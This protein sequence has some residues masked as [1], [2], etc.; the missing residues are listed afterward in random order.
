MAPENW[1]GKDSLRALALES[2]KSYRHHRDNSTLVAV[3]VWVSLDLANFDLPVVK[4]IVCGQE[5]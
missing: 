4:C 2:V 3:E 1:H 5:K